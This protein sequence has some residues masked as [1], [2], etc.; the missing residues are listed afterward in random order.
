[1]FINNLSN[2]SASAQ[3]YEFLMMSDSFLLDAINISRY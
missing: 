3:N 1:M 2:G